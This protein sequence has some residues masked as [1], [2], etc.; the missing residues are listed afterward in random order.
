MDSEK[1]SSLQE[2]ISINLASQ[3]PSAVL[4]QSPFRGKFQTISWLPGI[5]YIAVLC[6][7]EQA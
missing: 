1:C 2:A 4:E 3:S 5:K 7:E 6:G